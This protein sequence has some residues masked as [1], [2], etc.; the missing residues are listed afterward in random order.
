MPT[1]DLD[2][3]RPVVV[4]MVR[5]YGAPMADVDDLLQ[6]T[7]VSLQRT[8]FDPARGSWST[9]C[10]VVARRRAHDY[11]RSDRRGGGQTTGA[12]MSLEYLPT[13][14]M[15]GWTPDDT[16]HVD[17]ALELHRIL[18]TL[19]AAQDALGLSRTHVDDFLRLHLLHDG[20]TAS[21][22]AALR[23]PPASL[24][25]G[26]REVIARA[27]VIREALEAGPPPSIVDTVAAIP[28]ALG[29]HG[30]TYLE[31]AAAHGGVGSL[32]AHQ[33]A[34]L[35]GASYNTARQYWVRIQDLARM[36]AWVFQDQGRTATDHAVLFPGGL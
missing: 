2:A 29:E 30:R 20:D 5:Q 7:W 10:R 9:F 31:A 25:S 28:A 21:A 32:D 23:M 6:D 11:Y 19:Y 36:A 13:M 18:R 15:A 4:S 12:A 22:A 33:L 17:T 35:T 14:D 34:A 3:L 16:E 8:T 1:V 24:R 27:Q 26:C